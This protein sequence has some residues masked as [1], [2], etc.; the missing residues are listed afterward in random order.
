MSVMRKLLIGAALALALLPA[1]A[2]ADGILPDGSLNLE[3]PRTLGFVSEG[4]QGGGY[5]YATISPRARAPFTVVEQ[6]SKRDAKIA[7]WWSLEGTFGIPVVAA[8]RT[9]GGLSA[10]GGT[11]V[12]SSLPHSYPPPRSEFRIVDTRR[13][14]RGY[15]TTRHTIAPLN[16]QGAFT[17]DAISPDG[18]RIYL[19]HWFYAGQQVSGYELRVVNA[20]TGRPLPKPIAGFGSSGER[21]QGTA[22]TRLQSPDGRWVYTLYG[23]GTP[24]LE[25]LDTVRGQAGYVELPQLHGDRHAFELRM[26]FAAGGDRIEIYRETAQGGSGS[27]PLAEIDTTSFE[28]ARRASTA[29]LMRALLAALAALAPT[30]EDFLDFAETP[31]HPAG[32]PQANVLERVGVAGRSGEGRQIRLKQLGDPALPGRLLVF[33][34]IHGDECAA[35]KLDLLT[36]GCPDPRSNIFFVPNLDPDGFAAGTRVNGSGVDLNRNFPSQWRSSGAPGDPEYSG[37]RPLSEPETRLAARLVRR[38]R[39]RRRSGSTSTA[40]PALSSALGVRVL[41]LHVTSPAEPRFRSG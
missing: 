35:Q 3:G 20:A 34:C 6:I 1:S 36:N 2:R 37:P 4:V 16:L 5:R 33:G 7:R 40:A 15:S 14:A 38:L 25:A 13:L 22:I 24:F 10:D 28:F 12:L 19:T 32:E 21:L 39:P 23:A 41:P 18:S 27:D 30:H 9:A 17:F 11:L 29:P 31:R 26:L 8:D